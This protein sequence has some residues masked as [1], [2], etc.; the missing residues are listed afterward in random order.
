MAEQRPGFVRM[1]HADR[2]MPQEEML[3]VAKEK[4]SLIIGVP[5]E[6]SLQERRLALVPDGVALLV[7]NGHQ[8]LFE[9]G[10]GLAGHFPDHD[11]SEAGARIVASPEEVYKADIILKVAPV[12]MAET[13]WLKPKQILISALQMAVQQEEYFR[14]LMNRK[15]TALAY[16]LIRDRSGAL[17]VT[18]AMSEIA[19]SEAIFIA[20]E[21]LSCPE[22]GKG[23]MF[24]GFTGISPSE[25]VI[26]GAGT[27]GEFAARCAI[28]L[29]ALV[30]V[31]DNTIYRL[32]RLQNNLGTRVFTSILHPK[33][34][35]D[36]LR[37]ADVL[38]GAIHSTEGRSP[39]IIT[40]DMIRQMKEGSIVID[41]SIDQGGCFETSHP[42]THDDPVFAV[43]GVTH[44]CVPNIPSKVPH[45]ASQALNNIFVPMIL[46]AGAE[47]GF[48]KLIAR[49]YGL[50]QGIY[51]F[52][53]IGTN[54]FLSNRFNLPFQDID[55]LMAAFH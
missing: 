40:A 15:V 54:L 44:Y 20:A 53:G 5:K 39:C 22:K 31:F 51:V 4:S 26:I 48:E 8:V 23:K 12:T 33:A 19:G 14:A 30:K 13:E 7:R 43:S 50:R 24:G 38:I 55:L 25:V 34:L 35:S 2:L 32:R 46:N 37:S 16:E 18:R 41:V 49:D 27:V 28:G 6:I 17:P 45:T 21:Y 9:T 52:N 11:Y 47:G 3:E 29:G 42:T 1:S 10:A 36:A